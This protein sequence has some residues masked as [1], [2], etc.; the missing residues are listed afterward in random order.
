MD[1]TA[2]LEITT[3]KIG[4]LLTDKC[5]YLRLEVLDLCRIAM[6]KCNGLALK[7]NEQ[8][9]EILNLRKELSKKN[10]IIYGFYNEGADY[11]SLMSLLLDLFLNKMCVNVSEEEITSAAW[12]G[13]P[14][15][16]CPIKVCFINLKCKK[17]IFANRTRLKGSKIFINDD[18]PKE[19]RIQQGLERKKSIVVEDLKNSSSKDSSHPEDATNNSENKL[20]TKSKDGPPT[21]P[22]EM[23]KSATKNTPSTGP[24]L[25]SCENLSEVLTLDKTQ[26]NQANNIRGNSKKKKKKKKKR[27]FK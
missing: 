19:I 8:E 13:K 15:S 10:M 9:K 5:D 6:E 23:D 7:V 18:L 24:S 14:G 27:G 21:E 3:D 4:K 16:V 17:K 11:Q 26:K 1:F 25:S 20:V 2:A 12:L 22:T